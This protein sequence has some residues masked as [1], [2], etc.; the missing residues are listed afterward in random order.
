MSARSNAIYQPLRTATSIRILSLW[1]N[2]RGSVQ[3]A[4]KPVDLDDCPRF[5]TVSYAW[6]TATSHDKT[7]TINGEPVVVLETVHSLL[8]LLCDTPQ[9]QEDAYFWIDSICIDQANLKER[10][11]QVGLMDRVFRQAWRTIAWLGPRSPTT[12][13]AMDFL[14]T[15]AEAWRLRRDF[16][17]HQTR[18]MHPEVDVP[19][20]WKALDYLFS[21]SWWTRAWTLQEMVLPL[22]LVFYCGTKRIDQITFAGALSTLWACNP[23]EDLIRSVVWRRPWTRLRLASWY[24]LEPWRDS[25]SLVSL[26]AYSGNCQV[27]NPRDRIYS[28]LVVARAGDR[29][30]AGA[31]DYTLETRVAYINLVKNSIQKRVSL[32]IIC[33]AHIFRATGSKNPCHGQGTPTWVPDWSIQVAPFVTPAMVSQSSKALMPAFDPSG[34]LV[35]G[36]K[37]AYDAA[38]GRPQVSFSADDTK[39]TCRGIAIDHIDGLGAVEEVGLVEQST[40]VK[41]TCFS[42][43]YD[44]EDNLGLVDTIIRCLMLDCK[45]RYLARQISNCM[46]QLRDELGDALTTTTTEVSDQGMLPYFRSWLRSNQSLLLRG[47][48]LRDILQEAFV[49][50][51]P[52]SDLVNTSEDSLSRSWD[53]T[54][55]STIARRLLTTRKG[56][57]GMGPRHARKDDVVCV[58]FGCSVPVVLR[59]LVTVGGGENTN[60]EFVGECFL[61]GYMYGEGAS[62]PDDRE[63]QDFTLL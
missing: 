7:V 57:V 53:T 26:L 38:S 35:A 50:S 29:E 58:T 9:V 19:S 55:A 3:V 37:A 32:D 20:K 33:L 8:D 28:L 17:R 6:G 49:A 47:M 59:P 23:H 24:A 34:P 48:G 36:E 18:R 12:D 42:Y 13:E 27:T 30:L 10:E 54:T 22:R 51:R 4:L 40:S 25:M 1:R 46:A 31:P 56:L 62:A 11:T 5:T 63:E 39:M 52:T 60:F 61:D 45:D 21:L 43:D 16:A 44:P 2:E 15:L 14:V 41:N